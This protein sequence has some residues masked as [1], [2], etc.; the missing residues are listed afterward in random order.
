[1]ICLKF[2]PSKNIKILR[3]EIN[4]KNI[5]NNLPNNSVKN[6]L[7]DLSKYKFE[8]SANSHISELICKKINILADLERKAIL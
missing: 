2:F 1:M 8:S 6:L 5:L 7:T 3:I 4:M